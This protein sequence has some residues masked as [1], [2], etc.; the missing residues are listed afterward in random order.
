MK[1]RVLLTLI[2]LSV[3]SGFAQ[4]RTEHYVFPEFTEGIILLK[5]GERSKGVLNYNALTESII[6]QKDGRLMPLKN[7]LSRNADT[8]YVKN[9]KFVN[10]YGKF[11]ELLVNSNAV[12]FVQY[13]CVLKSNTENRNA[14]GSSSQTSTTVVAAQVR[15]Q[16][17]FYNLEL[18]ELYVAELKLRYH[19]TKDDK[20][21]TFETLRD[22][23]KLYANLKKEYNSYKKSNKVDYKEPR[24]VAN[25]ISY[26]ES[27]N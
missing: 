25:L 17:I 2:T 23:K 12:L 27:L 19:F 15:N 6:L 4:S 26:M 24:S 3:Y 7:D 5:N 14:Y 22:I 13:Y 16:G 10:R 18:P 9:R 20:E 1:K 8:L 11:M 21:I